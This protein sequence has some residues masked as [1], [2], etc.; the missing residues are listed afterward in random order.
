M[1]FGKIGCLI[2]AFISIILGFIVGI[3]SFNVVIPGIVAALWIAFGIGV[4]ALLL[5]ILLA[6][7]VKGR[8]EWCICENG[9]CIA[10]GAIG[11]IIST[12]IGL[13]ITITTGVVAIAVLL[14]ITTFFLAFT[15][16]GL[17]QLAIC[18]SKKKCKCRE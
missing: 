16:F 3:V 17:L 12:I 9:T 8:E 7:F 15:L 1:L 18:L 6:A 13:S 5:V 2:S 4:G 14:G 10:V 11:T